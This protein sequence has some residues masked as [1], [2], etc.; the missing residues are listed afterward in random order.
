MPIKNDTF[1]HERTSLN[2]Y[3]EGIETIIWAT[4]FDSN[5]RYIKL[6]VIDSDGGPI[7]T[8]GRSPVEGLYFIGIPWLRKRK[9][10]LI[11]GA[12]EDAAFVC[13]AIKSALVVI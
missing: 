8:E 1:I 3:N 4:G 13:E 10:A 12:A 7:H 5:Y 6:P 2:L 9:S 11:N